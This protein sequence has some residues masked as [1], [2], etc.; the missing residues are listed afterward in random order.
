MVQSLLKT[1]RVKVRYVLDYFLEHCLNNNFWET[2]LKS[3]EG[4]ELKQL[5]SRLEK[6]I[7]DP[8]TSGEREQ[9]WFFAFPE[10]ALA[11]P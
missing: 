8:V 5:S 11:P 2:R 4:G 9:V 3:Y 1:S 6:L 10:G 7:K